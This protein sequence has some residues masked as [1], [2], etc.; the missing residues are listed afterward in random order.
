MLLFCKNLH[1]KCLIHW[2]Q[3]KEAWGN[4]AQRHVKTRDSRRDED[5][6][7]QSRRQSQ[8]KTEQET[9]TDKDR[10]GDKDR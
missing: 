10:A 6:W 4:N 7:R 1:N 3:Q 9:K 8:I 5:T 2:S